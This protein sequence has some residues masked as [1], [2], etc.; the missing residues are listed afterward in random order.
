[1]RVSEA[2]QDWPGVV[3]ALRG[4]LAIR[5]RGRT[6]KSAKER[7]ELLLRIGE[8]AGD[9][10][11][12]RRG[13]V[14]LLPRGGC[15][16]TRIRRRPS[17]AS[18][19]WRRRGTRSAAAESRGM[20]LP[21]YERTENAAK[22]AERQRGP[23]LRRRHAG[24]AGR[25]AGEAARALRRPAQR[26]GE[27]L[28]GQPGAVRDRP[29]GR[30]RTASA[31]LGFAKAA[32]D[33][34]ELSDKLR[35]AVGATD[36]QTCGATSWSSS[37]SSRR[38]SLGAAARRRRSTRRSSPPSRCTPGPSARCRASTATG[39][40]WPEL[41]ALL[42]ARQLAA[43]DARERLDLL[44][45][46][47][48]LDEASLADPD[49][50]LGAYEKMLELDPSDLRA[51][52]ALERLYAARRALDATSKRCSA[53]GSAS[54]R[55]RRSP[56]LEFRRADLRASRLDNVGGA[57][58]LLEGDR[59]GRPQPRRRPPAAGEAA[60]GPRPAPARRADPGAGLREERRLGAAG[61]HL[62][63]PA[64]GA[65]GAGGG[66]AAG[67][68]GRPAGE[69][70][71]GAGRRAHHLAAGAGRR[72]EHPDALPEIERLATTLERF[73]ELVD[74][75]Q[76]LAFKRDASRHQ[77]P[78][79]SAVAGGEAL[80]R[81]AQQPAGRHRRLEAG[82]QPRSR[83][84]S[85]PRV[86]AAAALEALYAE[87]GDVANLVKTLR[88]QARWA[89][90]IG[91]AQEAP[92]PHRRARG[93]VAG[94]HRGGG[95]HAAL[96]PGARPPGPRPPST[97][98]TG[99]SRR[100]PTTASGWRSCASGSVS[101]GDAAAR[102]E[103]WRSIANLLEKDVGDV[104]EAIAACVSILDENPEDDQALETLARLYEQQGRHR[105][106]L[107]IVERR[108]ALRKP[109]D[110]ERLG[111]PQADRQAAGGAAR[112]RD[113]R[114]RALARGARTGAR[115]TA[116]RWRRWSVSWR[117][118]P[119]P[120]CAWPPRRCWSRSTK[121]VV[122]T[123][124]WPAIVRIY[125]DGAGRRPRPP[126]RADA[127]GGAGREAA[128]R[129][130]G[131]AAHDGA[132]DPRRPDRAGAPRAAGRVRAPGRARSAWP[133]SPRSIARSA[134]M[135][136]TRRSSSGSIAPSPPRRPGRVT[137]RRRPTTTAASSIGS[138]TT[139]RRWPRSTPSIAATATP[140]ALYEILLRRA[141]LAKEPAMRERAARPDRRAGGD[142]A[143][144]ARRRDHRLR[145][146]RRARA[147]RPRRPPRRSIASTP[148]PSAGAI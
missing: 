91:G 25:S 106:R 44:A 43:L 93:E 114:A 115:P 104:D 9:A 110:A 124:S 134:P 82:P 127:A 133:R 125:V 94:R 128:R 111:A 78:R 22:L 98:S 116:R 146:G 105:D 96:H 141:E 145:A 139:T 45:Q 73:A 47:A 52:R 131:G 112:R 2:R 38:S 8:P 148:R 122:A 107:E 123:P 130:R 53:R 87:T 16:P 102:Q 137:R 54:P 4:D 136:S 95:G 101:S 100:G 74:V 89:D 50:A 142:Q 88:Q 69:Q 21:L 32:G 20:T 56:E 18:S 27:G 57:L 60:G 126:R 42:D 140:Q 144:T 63:G 10:A 30:R 51:H 99:S 119:T 109:K 28:P 92:L 118:A 19:G 55:R 35:A 34:G 7:E 117:P 97:R 77:R 75:Y 65:A 17:P 90:G 49:H 143:R 29:H 39:Q 46:I 85:T 23:A 66:G 3:E 103:L 76:E 59:R 41:R 26:S 5:A 71:A 64:R 138:P 24:R 129:H 6:P 48:E 13:D 108:L 36:D 120:A 68:R 40:R 12:G 81:P 11:Q 79:R 62:R 33:T 58:D 61:R 72:P 15:R 121:R 70:A 80:R 37:P 86:P 132:G 135:S 83:T 84:T 113:G 1:M 67:A 147:R 31:L 14:R